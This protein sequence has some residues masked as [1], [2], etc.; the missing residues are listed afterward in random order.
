MVV[1]AIHHHESAIG[2]H[3]SPSSWTSLPP[4]TSSHS[5]RL[6]QT[7]DL[8]SLNHTANSH[9][10]SYF[11]YGNVYVLMN[12]Y[13]LSRLQLFATPWTITH[14]N[15]LSMEFSRQEYWSGLPF[16]SPGNLSDPGIE[17]RSPTFQA[18]A[19]SSAPPGKPLSYQQLCFQLFI[20]M[21]PEKYKY[22]HVQRCFPQNYYYYFGHTVK[23]VGS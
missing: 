21:I 2:I 16:P 20:K 17:P 15:P 14:Q 6:S 8:N 3:M 18:D 1:S 4:P 12:C 5:S 7:L 11:T 9:G 23:L 22:V 10:L 13:L 19:L